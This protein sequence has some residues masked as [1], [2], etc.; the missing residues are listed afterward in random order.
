MFQK[1]NDSSNKGSSG[2]AG[3]DA[4][5]VDNSWKSH[6]A[7]ITSLQPFGAPVGSATFPKVT[8]T[9]M[10]GRLVTW[11]LAKTPVAASLGI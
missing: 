3:G 1:M 4:K 7:L 9:A 10:D 6:Q 2:G 5:K 11:T 8:T